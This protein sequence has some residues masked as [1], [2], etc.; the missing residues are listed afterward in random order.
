MGAAAPGQQQK[1]N[2]P[3]TIDHW[4]PFKFS[5]YSHKQNTHV[6]VSKPN[7]DAIISMSCGNLGFRKSQRKR[8]DS[9]YQLLAFVLEQLYRDG[10]H[11]KINKLEVSLRGFGQGR[12][13]A[14]KILLGYEGR[15]LKDKIVAVM[16]ATKLKI[17]GTR[18]P[19][20]RRV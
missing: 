17:G 11:E 2:T 13:A 15:Y 8:Y 16:D 20:P 18:A 6:T 4:R 5:V 19:N 10:W 7:G 14:Q 9:A 3:R 12:Q 1:D